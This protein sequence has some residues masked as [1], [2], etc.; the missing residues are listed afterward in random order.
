MTLYPE[1]GEVVLHSVGGKLRV[2]SRAAWDQDQ[3]RSV[4]L[5]VLNE[6]EGAAL[7]WQLGYWL[8][9]ER[10]RPGYQMGGRVQADYTF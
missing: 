8:G 4:P 6:D 10:L 9:Q 2:I 7:A 3:A 5:F 1:G